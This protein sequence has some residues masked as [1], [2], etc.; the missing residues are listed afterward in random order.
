M[1]VMLDG[2]PVSEFVHFAR[3][4]CDQKYISPRSR[5]WYFFLCGGRKLSHDMS[6]IILLGNKKKGQRDV[7]SMA[8][9]LVARREQQ[10]CYHQQHEPLEASAVDEVEESQSQST[11]EPFFLF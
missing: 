1:K 10:Q 7:G 4:G 6:D 8:E 3:P 11:N 2:P 5:N 9:A